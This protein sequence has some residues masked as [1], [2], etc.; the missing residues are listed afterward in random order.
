MTDTLETLAKRLAVI[1]A[2]LGIDPEPEPEQLPPA[3]TAPDRPAYVEVDQVAVLQA[4][5]AA[6]EAEIL[7]AQAEVELWRSGNHP[8][9]LRGPETNFR[10]WFLQRPDRLRQSIAAKQDRL[11]QL[12]GK[13]RLQPQR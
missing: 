12:Q 8:E 4:A 13:R 11:N 7:E 2:R 5:I 1:E 10:P 3:M 6:E 9:F